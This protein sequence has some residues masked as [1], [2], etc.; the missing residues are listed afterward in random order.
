MFLCRHIRKYIKTNIKKCSYNKFMY[1]FMW[2]N[3]KSVHI[4][5]IVCFYVD[6]Y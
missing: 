1:V 2:T 4:T 6:E 5:E 3:I